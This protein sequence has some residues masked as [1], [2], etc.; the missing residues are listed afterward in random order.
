V[1]VR[2]RLPL[3]ATLSALQNDDVRI[4]Q[5]GSAQSATEPAISAAKP[6]SNGG[7][8]I[9]VF[10]LLLL[11][12]LMLLRRAVKRRSALKISATLAALAVLTACSDGIQVSGGNGN[13]NVTNAPN[14][15]PSF[16]S[17]PSPSAPSSNASFSLQIAAALADEDANSAAT[18]SANVTLNRHTGALQG[19][20]RH[21]VADATHAVIYHN[22]SGE[23][24]VLLG[25]A[26]SNLFRIPAG[27]K[28]NREQ[29]AAFQRGDLFVM[30]HSVAF[31]KGEISAQLTGI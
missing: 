15:N 25:K 16:A 6:A 21:G 23:G 18:G 26:D 19:S 17:I 9:S 12:P 31:P 2:S 7:G 13:G 8:S 3:M 14:N 5:R 1:K 30:I 27:T 24:I 20:I 11:A 22:G 29:I 10:G 28:L 4:T